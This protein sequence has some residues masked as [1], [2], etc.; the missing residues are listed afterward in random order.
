MLAAQCRTVSCPERGGLV[1]C[2]LTLHTYHSAI[3][4]T[5]Y[6]AGDDLRLSEYKLYT[7]YV[8]PAPVSSNLLTISLLLATIFRSPYSHFPSPNISQR[9]PLSGFCGFLIR[10]VSLHNS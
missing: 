8:L 7:T 6:D 2:K 9:V 10:S 5:F 4:R 3:H 1:I